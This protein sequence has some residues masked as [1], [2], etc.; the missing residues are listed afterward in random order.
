MKLLTALFS[1]TSLLDA[2]IFFSPLFSNIP[3]LCYSLKLKYKVLNPYKTTDILQHLHCF[4]ADEETKGSE[5][6]W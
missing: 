5:L 2:N 3:D 4:I 6:E 1:R